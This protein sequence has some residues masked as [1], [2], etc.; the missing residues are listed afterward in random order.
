M[1]NIK[2]VSFPSFNWIRMSWYPHGVKIVPK[3]IRGIL[4][5]LA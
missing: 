2:T 4:S 5:P 1:F 3:E